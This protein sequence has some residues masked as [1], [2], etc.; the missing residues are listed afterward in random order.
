MREDGRGESIWDRFARTP[1]TIVNG[2]TA[3]SRATPTTGTARTSRL[4]REL[5]LNAYRFS[6]AWP[7]VF[8]TGRGAANPAGLDFYDRFV[9]ELLENGIEPFATLYHWDLPQALEDRGG[10]PVRE[11]VGG[12]RRVRR[13]RRRA[14]RRPRDALDH[15]ERAVGDRLARVRARASTRPGVPSTADAIAAA[16]HVLLSHGRAVD[17]LRRQVPGADVGITIDVIP[18][19]PLT[20]SEADV[21]A[22]TARGRTAQPLDPRSGA[23]RR[24]PRGR[25]PA[26]RGVPARRARSTTCR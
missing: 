18:T 6:I 5:G 10:W 22:V 25:P 13:G 14:P 16:H 8:P 23:A 17:V 15:A 12:V 19:H 21:A 2:D 26:L 24:L 20:D 4:M 9:D 1:G 11:T 7:R 3:T